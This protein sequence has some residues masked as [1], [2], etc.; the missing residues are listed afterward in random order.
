MHHIIGQAIANCTLQ[1]HSDRLA[2]SEWFLN[3]HQ[4]GIFL[5]FHWTNVSTKWKHHIKIELDH[6]IPEPNTYPTTATA[7]KADAATASNVTERHKNTDP[8]AVWKS[9]TPWPIS[10]WW[11]WSR[12]EWVTASAPSFL[13]WEA[14]GKSVS[15]FNLSGS[16]TFRGWSEKFV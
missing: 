8:T 15:E 3:N 6:F 10:P 2:L 13:C 7:A 14:H 1:V 4:I 9:R 11:V 12:W 5:D 16:K